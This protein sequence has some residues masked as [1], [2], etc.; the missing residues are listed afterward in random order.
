MTVA[1]LQPVLSRVAATLARWVKAISDRPPDAIKP[2]ER[3]TCPT[4]VQWRLTVEVLEQMGFDFQAGRQDQSIHP[5]TASADLHDVRLTT[6]L[7][8]TQ[9]LSALFSSLHGGGHG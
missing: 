8:A 7:D 2:F 6:R 4:E 3:H 9:P 5:F 1:R